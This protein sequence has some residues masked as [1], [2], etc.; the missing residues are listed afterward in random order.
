[1]PT[2]I[3]PATTPQDF[4]AISSLENRVFYYDP[5]T[6][7]AFGPTRAS[8]DNIAKRAQ[9]LAKKPRNEGGRE[10]VM[11][12]MD[13][14]AVVI[15]GAAWSFIVAGGK[16]VGKE[17]DGRKEEM[18][19]GDVSWGFG[20]NVR[21]CE[22]VFLAADEHMLRSCEGRGYAKLST[23]I[24]APEHQRR[25]IGSQLLEQ[26]LR[27]VDEAGLQCVLAASKEGLELYKRFGFVEYE[28]MSLKLWE[29]K[30]G[31][32]LGEDHH[33]VMHRPAKERVQN[34]AL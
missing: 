33:V 11:M 10:V 20:A 24:V 26:G 21:F 31:G 1:M 14:K 15:G 32:G 18:E 3:L 6:V 25:G 5:F 19:E 16:E 7:V 2:T 28:T 9:G 23:I 17:A 22:D 4:H 13:E 29:Y 34:A 8:E 27:E 30:G 12:A